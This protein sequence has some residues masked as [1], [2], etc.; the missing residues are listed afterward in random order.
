MQRMHPVEAGIGG[1]DAEYIGEWGFS[2]QGCGCPGAFVHN[3]SKPKKADKSRA[4]A[5]FPQFPQALLLLRIIIYLLLSILV[6]G[7]PAYGKEGA[8]FALKEA[9]KAAPE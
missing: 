4:E 7:A 9:G 8:A 6:L 2:P 5:G 1:T 3:L